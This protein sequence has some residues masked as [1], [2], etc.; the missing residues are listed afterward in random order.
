VTD[1]STDVAAAAAAPEQ[2]PGLGQPFKILWTSSA[3]STL[4]DGVRMTAF[5]L[6]AAAVTRNPIAVA[7]VAAA[8]QLP[9]ILTSLI[10]G[11]LAD[12]LDRRRLMW[13]V[14]I[15]RAV[16]M[17][18]LTAVVAFGKANILTLC[19]VAFV[20]GV[21][22]TLFDNANHAILPSVVQRDSIVA[23]NGRL[24]TARITI[25]SFVGPPLG[26]V[27]FAAAEGAPFLLDAI[28]FALAS[29]LVGLLLRPSVEVTSDRRHSSLKDDIAEG[30]KWV[31][32]SS[33]L[34]WAAVFVAV[35]NF[36]QAA[37]Q[38][39]LVLLALE[40]LGL[41]QSGYG[42]LVGA[43]G[44]GGLIGGVGGGA[45]RRRCRPGALFAGTVLITVPIFV[46]LG[47]TTSP[48]VAGA[49]LALNSFAGITAS[50]LLSSL[51]QHIVPNEL[52]ARV[53]SVMGLL[54]MGIGLPLGSIAGGL[55]AHSLGLRSPFYISAAL[56]ALAAISIPAMAR[57]MAAL[58]TNSAKRT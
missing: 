29:M 8:G 45:L 9:W 14:D 11:A 32:Q 31:W 21:G 25:N 4:G 42:L 36:T 40:D 47:F 51:R 19:C 43:M 3:V 34:R 12:R 26:G 50:V 6:L 57:A 53:N 5:P 56:I 22:Q 20:L 48:Y 37:T 27:L 58:D 17:F 2:A 39:V 35:V 49:M 1:S 52:L 38:T 44:V 30:I 13:T 18:A 23:A 33:V 41:K 54:G 24:F 15:F 55:L 46:V 28:S 16:V 10:G 7:A